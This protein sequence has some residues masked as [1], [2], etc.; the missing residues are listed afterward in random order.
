MGRM[1]CKVAGATVVM[2]M[3]AC[4]GAYAQADTQPTNSLP[5]PYHNAENW[6]KLPEGRV[7]GAVAAVGVDRAG[8]IWMLQ[9]CGAN[10]CAGSA[11]DPILEFDSSGKFLKSFGRGIFV[12]PHS[13]SLD[14]DGNI[15][16][17][18]YETKDGKGLQVFK[19]SQDGKILM[20]LG[21]TGVAGNE[22]DEFSQPTEVAVAPNGDIFVG[23][24]HGGN[25]NERIV[26]FSKNGKFI[27]AWGS[28]GTGRGEFDV[29]HALAFDNEGRLF[30]G[31]RANNRIQ[32]FDQDG[33]FVAEWK[34]FSRPSGI[35]IDKNDVIY[36]ADGDSN[37]T[38]NPGWLRGIR[39]GSA[40]NG[41]VKFLIPDPNRDPN[42]SGSSMAEGLAVDENGAVYAA[43]IGHKDLKKFVKN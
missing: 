2:T 28:K 29:I 19:F 17:S 24:G 36:V 22:P 38:T 20:T 33:N 27:K 37:T 23:D 16:V 35:Y 15:W 14:K 34:Q 21:K 11:D 5:N 32:I 9:R 41:T 31:D 12:T 3:F 7:L 8:H 13:M 30:V 39:I 40:K 1:K 10:T 42:V 6:L 4:L 18:D 25:S 43:E 26:K